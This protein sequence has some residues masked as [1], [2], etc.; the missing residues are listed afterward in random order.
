[1]KVDRI[2][3]V[4]SLII[5]SQLIANQNYFCVK[6]IKS[7]KILINEIEKTKNLQKNITL[8]DNNTLNDIV[9]IHKNIL[10]NKKN[11]V[12]DFIQ[13]ELDKLI[14][15]EKNYYN[16]YSNTKKNFTE[17]EFDYDIKNTITDKSQTQR[18]ISNEKSKH[19]IE[20]D[21]K[22]SDK[23]IDKDYI[24][25]IIEQIKNK[26]DIAKEISLENFEREG[27][28]EAEQNQEDSKN[29]ILNIKDK[30]SF[31]TILAI[32]V[33]TFGFFTSMIIIIFS[34]LISSDFYQEFKSSSIEIAVTL[35]DCFYERNKNF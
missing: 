12:S 32:V 33:I 24:D 20:V 1:M 23:K 21:N 34:F 29:I 18:E 4:I 30:F 22:N 3:F 10:E 25:K 8:F 6:L 14:E 35:N 16:L 26:L 2:S 19:K 27:K 5:L 28:K 17:R 31:S 9:K 11:F 15:Y 7:T 13:T